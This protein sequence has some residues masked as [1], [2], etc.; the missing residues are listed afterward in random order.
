MNQNE[1]QRTKSNQKRTSTNQKEAKTS[2]NEPKRTQN[3]QQRT[4]TNQKRISMNQTRSKTKQK[5]I[6]SLTVDGLNECVLLEDDSSM[7]EGEQISCTPTIFRQLI[8]NSH[9]NLS[10]WFNSFYLND[11]TLYV[12]IIYASNSFVLVLFCFTLYD[13]IWFDWGGLKYFIFIQFN[14]FSY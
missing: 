8:T 7:P 1:Q 10:K 13:L 9:L 4:K 5:R 3:E 12:F 2:Q 11:F 14:I 6:T